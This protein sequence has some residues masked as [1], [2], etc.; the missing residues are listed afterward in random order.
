MKKVCFVANSRGGEENSAQVTGGKKGRRQPR[1][2]VKSRRTC[3]GKGTQ[4]REVIGLR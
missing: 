1:V 4:C 3:F 2:G